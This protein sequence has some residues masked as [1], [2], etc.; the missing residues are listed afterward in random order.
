MDIDPSTGRAGAAS[1]TAPQRSP[2]QLPAQPVGERGAALPSTIVE[3]SDEGRWLAVKEMLA[4]AD[5]A[6]FEEFLPSSALKDMSVSELIAERDKNIISLTSSPRDPSATYRADNDSP[7]AKEIR[8]TVYAQDQRTSSARVALYDAAS[9]FKALASKELSAIKGTFDI[10]MK[11][12]K[13]T[14]IGAELSKTEVASLQKLL[15]DEDRTEAV[16]LKA[17][18]GKFNEEALKLINYTIEDRGDWASGPDAA[19]PR[20]SEAMLMSE[21]TNGLSYLSEADLGAPPARPAGLPA[22]I[23]WRGAGQPMEVFLL[24]KFKFLP[25]PI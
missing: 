1:V 13:L 21:F 5:D 8:R 25:D 9:H 7:A 17:A 16:T 19:R 14:I 10:S 11:D 6:P 2:V 23:V 15:D 22:D 20:R 4:S 12:G 24:A 3:L 18:I